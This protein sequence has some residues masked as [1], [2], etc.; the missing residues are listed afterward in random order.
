M[1]FRKRKICHLN[2]FFVFGATINILIASCARMNFNNGTVPNG[3][4]DFYKYFR[5]MIVIMDFVL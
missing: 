1:N 3:V 4:N 2:L 5:R